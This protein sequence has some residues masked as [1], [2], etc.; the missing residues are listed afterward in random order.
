ML[1]S[2]FLLAGIPVMSTVASTAMSSPG[3]T[4]LQS[5]SAVGLTV[6]L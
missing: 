6:F 4:C 1:L 3:N 5:P 2:L